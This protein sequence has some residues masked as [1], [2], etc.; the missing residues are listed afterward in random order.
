MGHRD[1]NRDG[2]RTGDL[3]R[4]GFGINQ[5]GTRPGFVGTLV[6]YFSEGCLVGKR[7]KE[8]LHFIETVK[9]DARYQATDRFAFDTTVISGVALYE[10]IS[11][12]GKSAPPP[13]IPP[14]KPINT[15]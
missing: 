14:K 2:F 11:S 12:I 6:G 15:L 10:F 3:V 4:P 8:H 9:I 5:H 7:W 13:P 1:R